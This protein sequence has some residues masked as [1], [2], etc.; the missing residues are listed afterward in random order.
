MKHNAL[1]ERQAAI[2]DDVLDKAG[3]ITQSAYFAYIEPLA[4]LVRGA[5]VV[6]SMAGPTGFI[7][8]LD[9][10]HWVCSAFT[11]ERLEWAFDSGKPPQ[12]QIARL[13]A[14]I[15]VDGRAPLACD[16]PYA[17]ETCAIEVEIQKSHGRQITGLAYGEACF[18]F[19]FDNGYE[20]E[21]MLIPGNDGR[22]CL[23]VFW[24]RW[25]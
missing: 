3:A 23:R 25:S 10:G 1:P 6:N 15:A 21:T 17:S 22:L 13:R 12:E 9:S 18:N 16:Y 7:L 11:G 2:P 24:E 5:R 19:C 20:L 4:S 14:P 8:I